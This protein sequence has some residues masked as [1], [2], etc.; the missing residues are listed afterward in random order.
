MRPVSKSAA[1]V[2]L[3]RLGGRK[4]G[5]ARAKALSGTTRKAIASNAAKKR[6]GKPTSYQRAAFVKRRAYVKHV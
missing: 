4:G 3:G 6:W 1:A 5:P 2:T